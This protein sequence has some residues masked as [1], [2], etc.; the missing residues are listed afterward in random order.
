MDV[1]HDPSHVANHTE[2]TVSIWNNGDGSDLITL[3][4]GKDRGWASS[5]AVERPPVGFIFDLSL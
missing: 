5:V 1:P 2:G 3:G 4:A